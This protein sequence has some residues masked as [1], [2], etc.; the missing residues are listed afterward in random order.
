MG[1][2]K[3]RVPEVLLSKG[4]PVTGSAA[5]LPSA[6]SSSAAAKPPSSAVQPA[7]SGAYPAR[8][9]SS[10]DDD[11]DSGSVIEIVSVGGVPVAPAGAPAGRRESVV[12]GA[13]A[14][15]QAATQ[16]QGPPAQAPT[17]A[18]AGREARQE[19][20][21]AAGSSAARAMEPRMVEGEGPAGESG[22]A[23]AVGPVGARA[24]AVGREGS[25]EGG[26]RA[27]PPGGARPA[28]KRGRKPAPEVLVL[29]DDSSD[30]ESIGRR[31]LPPQGAA[32]ERW[33][34]GPTATA[35]QPQ[36]NGR[37]GSSASEGIATPPAQ[38]AQPVK[39]LVPPA[40][41]QPR[42]SGPSAPQNGFATSAT[43]ERDG[44]PG[45]A[46]SQ[47]PELALG[48]RAAADRASTAPTSAA[49]ASTSKAV[50]RG[51]QGTRPVEED[52]VMQ[53]H[54][55][56]DHGPSSAEEAPD[57]EDSEAVSP[58]RHALGNR[59]GPVISDSEESSGDEKEEDVPPP[60]APLARLGTARK[61]TGGRPPLA[62]RSQPGPPAAP[63]RPIAAAPANAFRGKA[64]KATGGRPP[65]MQAP[66]AILPAQPAAQP[67]PRSDS[68][69]PRPILP[70]SAPAAAAATAPLKPTPPAQPGAAR[71]SS[72]GRPPLA[73]RSVSAQELLSVVHKRKAVS[74]SPSAAS[75]PE[76]PLLKRQKRRSERTRENLVPAIESEMMP[77][78]PRPLPRP[79]TSNVPVKH[80]GD[81]EKPS[82]VLGADSVEEDEVVDP[83]KRAQ[84]E[85]AVEEF[86]REQV[87][88]PSWERQIAGPSYDI[89]DEFSCE[90]Q[91]GVNRR[92]RDWARQHPFEH[93][94]R[95]SY[96]VLFE[97]MILEANAQEYPPSAPD[98]RPKIRIVPPTGL[99]PHAW[100]SPPFDVVYSDGIV[101]MQAPGCGCQGDCGNPANR[102]KCACRLRQI[103]ASR[104]RDGGGTRSNH[105]DFA[106]E[107]DMR[108]HA[109][110]MTHG[111]PIVECNSECG[112][113]SNCINR[114][115]G[116]RQGISVDIY[117]TGNNG[118]GVRLPE[119]YRDP[120]LG[121]YS[122][123]VV[124]RGEPL[125]VYAG[126]LLRSKDAHARDEFVYSI[127]KRNYIYDLDLWTIGEDIRALAP[128]QVS[129]RVVV[130][131][132]ES[133]HKSVQPAKGKSK[134]KKKPAVAFE[135]EPVEIQDDDAFSSLFSVD[136]F[137]MGNWTR[138]A[139]HVCEGFN[140][141]P[142]PVYV[143]E[144]DLS[145][146]LWVYFAFR[147]IYPGEEINISYFSEELPDPK[148]FGYTA[149]EWIRAA[150]KARKEAPAS[151]RCYCG[152][153]LCRGRMFGSDVPMFYE[154][155]EGRGVSG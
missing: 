7:S 59:P 151:H 79:S 106:Y 43:P 74:P 68:T 66:R 18:Q 22:A 53:T 27:A 44:S 134:G 58:R 135:E 2:P 139:N 4:S 62:Q 141:I 75:D 87:L 133:A 89:D 34:A 29:F 104:T 64:R 105:A 26:A 3:G 83:V 153:R 82:F 114:V 86:K 132:Q 147:D 107:K 69:T 142:R 80:V 136:A 108:L 8:A 10:S 84:I 145:R 51:D 117:F 20:H 14:P 45:L 94:I 32:A 60:P 39:A 111:D 36:L 71:K 137:T 12:Q 23:D 55:D 70:A 140:V 146:P 98:F 77:P 91:D 9:A 17:Q 150:D 155:G 11:S 41:P 28:Q 47:T 5:R 73:P 97:Q 116:N 129:N 72:G 38:R 1:K 57:D 121:T 118:W 138:F 13:I 110:V 152:K 127:I 16:R 37:A 35:P 81:N 144:G 102:G 95:D 119:S 78:P 63:Q 19:E 148:Q 115:V 30:D 103:A 149:A 21:P 92:E 40:T 125:A 122:S 113:S 124:R 96:K 112:C 52:V 90:V 93:P 130:A 56:D 15:A 99:S 67:V 49:A 61:A 128:P 24:P 101:P 50:G 100:S 109:K 65:L 143:D 6:A 31:S 131:K 123:R 120:I 46:E 25:S 76:A 48:A 85:A 88:K 42:A 126:E 54:D 33:A 154:T